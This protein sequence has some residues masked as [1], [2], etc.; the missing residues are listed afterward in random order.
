MKKTPF[1]AS[2]DGSLKDV[3][4]RSPDDLGLAG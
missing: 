3:D 1:P 2:L 4:A